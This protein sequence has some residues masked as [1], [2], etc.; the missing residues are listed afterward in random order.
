[1]SISD[2]CFYKKVGGKV[3]SNSHLFSSG[4]V[5]GKNGL[6]GQIEARSPLGEA[7]RALVRL[8]SGEAVWIAS[9][10]LRRQEDGSYVP[11]FGPE[12]ARERPQESI[13]QGETI[14]IPVIA[15]Q[16]EVHKRLVETGRVRITKQV[17]EYQEV[18]EEPLLREQVTVE[19]VPVHRI[20]ENR[21]AGIRQE[22]DITV[23]PVLEEVLVVE[24]RLLLKEE[25]RIRRAQT[26]SQEP[27][28]VTL[29]REEIEMER[30][31]PSSSEKAQVR[32]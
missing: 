26:T 15:E 11:P 16:A 6:R 32:S 30:I 25:V 7:E 1:M 31:E 20:I 21:E 12:E 17:K 5:I 23:I 22:G 27:Q 2:I 28:I 13:G 24:K 3:E 29:R 18:I 9:D 8:D 10:L 4:I 14:T 19:R